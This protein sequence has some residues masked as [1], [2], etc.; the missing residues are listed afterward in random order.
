MKATVLGL[1]IVIDNKTYKLDELV[2][3][4]FYD[5]SNKF[6]DL[7]HNETYGVNDLFNNIVQLYFTA[8][9]WIKKHH[10]TELDARKAGD[11][12][13][14]IFKDVCKKYD[15][16]F[17]GACY[18]DAIRVS[19][20]YLINTF[21]ESV[22]FSYL[23]A[24]IPY[25]NSPKVSE[26]FAVLRH[27]GAIKK[28]KRF[29]EI[30]QEYEDLFSKDSIYR[31]FPLSK[32]LLWIWK[33]YVN[34]F[35]TLRV[36]KDFYGSRL[37]SW[38]FIALKQFYQKRIVYAEM[39][40][41]MLDEYFTYFEGKEFYTGNNLDR[42]SVIEDQL[43]KKHNIKTYN[44]P[45][46]IE[47]GF[48]FPKGFSSDVF[49]AHSQYAADYLNRLYNTNKYVYDET[50]ISRM[51]AYN[52]TTPHEQMVLFFTEPRDV[53]VNLEIIKGILPELKK[54]GKILYLKLHPG[55]NKDNYKGLDVE[56]YTDYELSLTGNICISRKSTILL[57]AI[58]NNSVPIAIIT[59]PKDQSTFNQF[60]ALNAKEI[61]KTYNVEELVDVIKKNQK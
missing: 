5:Y 21:C 54:M 46:G 29:T 4:E 34:S 1:D 11:R 2:D 32:R 38:T 55:D 37:G 39:Y 45:H 52:C 6:A 44:I 42:Y 7:F 18:Y 20:S 50:V 9:L 14:F 59:N 58:H 27:K 28:F 22:Y 24:K 15:V 23:N 17:K 40:K 61:I 13:Y 16:K 19:A 31:L 12:Y 8:E 25:C 35:K 36:F 49:Y 56:F 47:Y 30:S 60:P 33:A 51:F 26:K 53:Y 57:E 43:A 48:K 41:L 10:I 3:D